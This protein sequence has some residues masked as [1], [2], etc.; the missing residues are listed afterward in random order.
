MLESLALSSGLEL[1]GRTH[2]LAPGH[3]LAFH[4]FEPHAVPPIA[5]N[6]GERI[7]AVAWVHSW[8]ADPLERR[9]LRELEGV[10]AELAAPDASPHYDFVAL[11]LFRHWMR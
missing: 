6:G 2:F 3:A 7:A 8:I 4:A 1:L 9:I 5:D 11:N 10:R